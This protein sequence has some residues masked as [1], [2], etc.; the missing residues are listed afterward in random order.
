MRSETT[1]LRSYLIS[2]LMAFAFFLLVERPSGVAFWAPSIAVLY[3]LPYCCLGA[4]KRMAGTL[5]Y[6]AT[7]G[8]FLIATAV[9]IGLGFLDGES[10]VAAM[11]GGFVWPRLLVSLL[12]SRAFSTQASLRLAMSW[13]EPL[14]ARSSLQAQSMAA[15]LSL[16]VFFT[17][18]FY[19]F[20]AR[21]APTGG[22]SVNAV[23]LA[24]LTGATWIHFSIV[25]LTFV[26]LA[27]VLESFERFFKNRAALNRIRSSLALRCGAGEVFSNGAISSSLE[28]E[29]EA[30]G[31]SMTVYLL[32]DRFFRDT[33]KSAS[34][35]DSVSAL[36][37]DFFEA[38]RRFVRNM[39]PLLP[40]LG[41]M[42]TVLGLSMSMSE[43]QR[44]FGGGGQAIDVS[45]ALTGLAI[46]FQTTILGLLGSLI[47]L[48]I[49]NMLDK[50]E[51]EFV[52]EC[53]WFVAAIKER[54]GHCD[55][56]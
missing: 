37:D 41:F 16:G 21:P 2:L 4:E 45:G 15:A 52:A 25:L 29:V 1:K 27:I 56:Q 43:L 32:E 28:Q 5:A 35:G 36:Y 14:G 26:M 23:L 38:W 48:P 17:E 46:K 9:P 24:A 51:S 20:G 10:P 12:A 31:R 44:G 8:V 19:I 54:R 33:R 39:L 49:L 50:C 11:S 18:L 55:A 6:F 42:G 22:G 13:E 40:L 3:A 53:A 7:L 47:M 30:N 34:V